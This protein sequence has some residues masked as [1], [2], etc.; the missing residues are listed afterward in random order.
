MII[1]IAHED[2]GHRRWPFITIAIV[3]ICGIVHGVVAPREADQKRVIERTLQDSFHYHAN[4]P[5]LKINPPLDKIIG[6]VHKSRPYVKNPPQVPASE[7]DRSKEQTILDDLGQAYLRG[8]QERPFVKY[9]FVPEREGMVQFFTHQFLHGDWL[10]L[11]LN[12]WFLWLC[13]V[14][15]ED[16]WGRAVYGPFYFAAGIAAALT[17][18]FFGGISD[19]P[20]IGASGAVAGAMGAFLVVHARTRIRFVSFLRFHP[21]FFT[22]RAYV[23]L[24]LWFASEVFYFYFAKPGVV[25][26]GAHI[27]GF[28]FGV[29]VAFVLRQTGID[30]KLDAAIEEKVTIKQD[31]RLVEASDLVTQGR[32]IEAIALLD[33]VYAESPT[34]IDV[35]LETLRAAKAANQADRELTAY[36]RLMQ[37]YIRENQDEPAIALF[38]E[39]RAEKRLTGLPGVVLMTMGQRMELAGI[40]RD[41]AQAYEALHQGNP[42]SL[43]A[44]KAMVAQAKIEA[45]IGAVNYARELFTAARESPF[46]TKEMDDV[47]DAELA[48]LP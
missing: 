35:Q 31:P 12:M 5:Y 46:S 24:P 33:T 39:L 6:Y 25:A 29:A 34:N 32:P 36:G 4:H 3:A 15:L 16:R 21:M 22:A 37:L 2:M 47:V 40:E 1:P 18:L 38:R 9:G 41:A 13:G 8:I 10:H 20:R 42:T 48:K 23:M 30:K 17:E 26:H 11:I 27:G 43:V 44:V 45:R 14:N 28:I 19:V 7:E